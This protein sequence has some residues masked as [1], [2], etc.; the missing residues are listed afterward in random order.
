MYGAHQ[1][2]E[3]PAVQDGGAGPHRLGLRPHVGAVPAAGKARR[4][5]SAGDGAEPHLERLPLPYVHLLRLRRRNGLPAVQV[6]EQ[7]RGQRQEVARRGQEHPLLGGGVEQHARDRHHGCASLGRRLRGPLPE[8][9]HRGALL[10]PRQGGPDA[11]EVPLH[12]VPARR[13]LV[14]AGVHR[15]ER[16]GEPRLRPPGLRRGARLLGGAHRL[17]VLH[18]GHPLH[19]LAPRAGQLR[20]RLVAP[21][22]PAAG[23]GA[24]VVRAGPAGEHERLGRVHGEAADRLQPPGPARQHVRG[25][26]HVLDEDVRE[27]QEEAG[28]GHQED[29]DCNAAD[30]SRD[31]G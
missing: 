24:H 21:L 30:W 29:A 27:G 20:G 12:Q 1:L 16:A 4:E 23:R 22:H 8:D 31:G 28:G 15:Q 3:P 6:R 11:L 19:A 18:G 17:H 2:L 26:L 10:V 25:P 7:H 13:A 9:R 5:R 14:G